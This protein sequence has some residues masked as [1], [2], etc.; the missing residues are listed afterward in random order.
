MPDKIF[1]IAYFIHTVFHNISPQMCKFL[2]TT[3]CQSPMLPIT[4]SVY[5]GKVVQIP[6][7]STWH[8]SYIFFEVN[9]ILSTQESQYFDLN[10]AARLCLAYTTILTHKIC[11][12]CT[13]TTVI[14]THNEMR[15]HC[16]GFSNLYVLAD[17]YGLLNTTLQTEVKVTAHCNI[18]HAIFCNDIW[19]FLA[20]MFADRLQMI[21]NCMNTVAVIG[22]VCAL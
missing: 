11:I 18:W 16:T 7:D 8:N 21:N 12:C 20:E 1:S 9:D 10:G 4:V 19:L 2:S 22:N 17:L 6:L 3:L 15:F 13:C 5:W 14:S